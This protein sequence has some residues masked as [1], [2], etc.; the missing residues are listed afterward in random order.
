MN[1]VLESTPVWGQE[2]V[3]FRGRHVTLSVTAST[4]VHINWYKSIWVRISYGTFWKMHIFRLQDLCS[5]YWVHPQWGLLFQPNASDAGVVHGPHVKKRCSGR[6]LEDTIHKR[7]FPGD[8]VVKNLPAM[9]KMQ[10]TWVW[11]LGQEDT[12]EESMATQSSILA[13]R[14][15]HTEVPSGYSP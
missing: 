11:S 8:S 12:L 13:W 1:T 5:L 4:A 10:E 6:N 3:H 14:I 7:G 15:P 2:L 9:Q